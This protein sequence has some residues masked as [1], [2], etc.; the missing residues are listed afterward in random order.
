MVTIPSA[1][2]VCYLQP[3]DVLRPIKAAVGEDVLTAYGD[4]VVERYRLKDDMY[5]IRLKGWR[6]A[7]LY[8]KAEK[9]DRA[10][11]GV[12]DQGSFGMKWLLDMFFSS[13]SKNGTLTRSRSNSVTSGRS[14]TTYSTMNE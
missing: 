5:E 4:G 2:M 10:A 8:A 6:G 7:K 3:E 11:D 14:R 9:F 12:N 1:G 13:N